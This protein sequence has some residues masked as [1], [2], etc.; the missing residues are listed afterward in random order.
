MLVRTRSRANG[1]SI[2]LCLHDELLV[3]A[4]AAVGQ[5]VAATLDGCLRE[6]AA[7][8]YGDVPVRFLADTSVV[9]SWADAK[10]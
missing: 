6:A 5:E 2:V 9:R 10:G 1:G 4:P 3:H 8:L 7:R